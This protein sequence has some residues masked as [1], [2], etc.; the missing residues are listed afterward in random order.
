MVGHQHISVQGAALIRKSFA[1]PI[2]IKPALRIL[3]EDRAAIIASL[4]HM[5]GLARYEKA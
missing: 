3:Q 5:L 4:D 2:Q 1:K